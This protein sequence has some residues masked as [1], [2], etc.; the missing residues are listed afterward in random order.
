MLEVRVR[1]K[2]LELRETGYSIKEI[3]EYL[4]ISKSTISLLVRNVKLS[5]SALE[6]LALR[7]RTGQ[8]KSAYTLKQRR[9][10]REEQSLLVAKK[11]FQNII[12]NNAI[13]LLLAS[14]IYEC[15]GGKSNFGVLEFTNSDPLLIKL[16]LQLLRSSL[17]ID[18]NKFRV[19]MHLHSYHSEIQEKRFWSKITKIPEDKFIKTFQKKESGINL[20]EGYRGCVQIKYYD[21]NIKRTLLAGKKLL[22][23]KL[24]L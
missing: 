7:V 3:S 19:A 9:V 17:K 1:N 18:E 16:F 13:Y 6:R 4:K 11:S 12:F 22:A 10:K 15:E 20:K 5:K 21:V 8:V 14:M 24:G 23:N 2:A